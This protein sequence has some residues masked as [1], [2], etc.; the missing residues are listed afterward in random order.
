MIKENEENI[1]IE[2]IK[3]KNRKSEE[4]FYNKYKSIL[5]RY[6]K[7]KYSYNKDTE[8]DV[9]EIINKV[10]ENINQY[11][12]TKSKFSTWV[13][14]ITKNHMIDKSR[15]K[16]FNI[17][18]NS[19][20]YTADNTTLSSFTN[21]DNSFTTNVNNNIYFSRCLISDDMPDKV[22]EDN[23]TLSFISNKIGVKDYHLLNMK[24]KQGYNYNEINKEMGITGS[25]IIPN[26]INYLKIKLKNEK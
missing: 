17:T 10:F 13:L 11:D 23:S 16:N 19:I 3:N 14:N 2:N 24:Y 6:I 9:S 21:S 20:S 22:F 25:T 15:T 5:T 26:R 12:S 1:L 18:S 7:R 4:A 8:D